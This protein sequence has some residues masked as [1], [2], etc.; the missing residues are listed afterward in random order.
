[1]FHKDFRGGQHAVDYL[2][3]FAGGGQ[4]LD[5]QSRKT[6]QALRRWAATCMFRRRSTQPISGLSAHPVRHPVLGQFLGSTHRTRF[7]APDV[8]LGHSTFQSLLKFQLER[9]AVLTVRTLVQLN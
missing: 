4:P 9:A 8:N 1:L 6:Y 3:S 7:I 2:C 5:R